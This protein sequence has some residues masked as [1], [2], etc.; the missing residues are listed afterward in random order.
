MNLGI[1][2]S[3]RSYVQICWVTTTFGVPFISESYMYTKFKSQAETLNA[4]I[5]SKLTSLRASEKEKDRAV[6]K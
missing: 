4:Q 2:L 1:C 3:N 5:N 6:R